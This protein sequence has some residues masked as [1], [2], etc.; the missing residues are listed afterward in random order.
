MQQMLSLFQICL[1]HVEVM[2]MTKETPFNQNYYCI[3]NKT[4]LDGTNHLRTCLH[5][6]MYCLIKEN[7][8]LAVKTCYYI[9]TPHAKHSRTQ[10]Q[11]QNKT[12]QSES[13][14]RHHLMEDGDICHYRKMITFARLVS[15]PNATIVISPG[16]S[17]TFCKRKSGPNVSMGFLSDRVGYVFPSP[18]DPCTKSAIR[19]FT[20]P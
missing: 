9:L 10:E 6:P 1:L 17:F 15:G 4:H 2:K 11:L 13:E 14:T 8:L 3:N 5:P 12:A 7:V 16:N 19:F 18:S 20:A